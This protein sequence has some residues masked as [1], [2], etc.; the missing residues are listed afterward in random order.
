MPD[1]QRAL[2]L[3]ADSVNKKSTKFVANSSTEEESAGSKWSLSALRAHIEGERG[4]AAWVGVWRQVRVL[5][6]WCYSASG[7]TSGAVTLISLEC[8]VLW[9]AMP[10]SPGD[11]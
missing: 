1:V 10:G 5:C 11:V 9:K 2:V 6:P 7:R 4:R 8:A 3:H